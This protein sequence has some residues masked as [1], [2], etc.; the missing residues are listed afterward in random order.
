MGVV[1]ILYRVMLWGEGVEEAKY[2]VFLHEPQPLLLEVKRLT[3][4][5][6]KLSA[7]F[8]LDSA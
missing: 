6:C 2:P 4:S 3:F 8:L 1:R 7:V 5:L